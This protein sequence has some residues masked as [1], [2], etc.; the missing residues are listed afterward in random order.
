VTNAVC[1]EN[2]ISSASAIQEICDFS[3]DFA[4]DSILFSTVLSIKQFMCIDVRTTCVE[5]RVVK[6][7]T[8]VSDLSCVSFTNPLGV[9]PGVCRQR[10]ALTIGPT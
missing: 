1:S 9:I 8:L 5:I 4:S 6:I 10:L 2:C 3:E 7:L